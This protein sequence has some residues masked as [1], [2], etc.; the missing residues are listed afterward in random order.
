MKD[1]LNI[2]NSFTIFGL[3]IKYYGLIMALSYVLALVVCIILCRKKHYNENLPYKLLMLVFPLAVIG[4]RL[5]YVLFSDRSWTFMEVLD[6]RSGGLMLYGGI[7]LALVGVI[8]Y[9][10]IKNKNPLKYT[11]LIAPCLIIAQAL[12][13]WGNFFNQEAYGIAV[14]NSA[15]H[16]FPFAVFIEADGLWHYATFFYESMWCLICF[17]IL[18]VV[19]KKTK[20]AG[21]STSLYLVLYGTERLLVEGLRTDSLYL[22]TFRVSQLISIIMIAFGVV[23]LTILGIKTHKEKVLVQQKHDESNVFGKT[24]EE[25]ENKVYTKDDFVAVSDNPLLDSTHSVL[26]KAETS[27]NDR[28]EKIKQANRERKEKL[29]KKKQKQQKKNKK[30][31]RK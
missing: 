5:G 6:I 19:Y 22:G 28:V 2:N 15:F 10:F 26:N 23:Y 16:W 4:G 30:N 25:I 8:V 17:V 18:F 12:G 21:I 9:A 29:E 3:E 1:L 24:A 27:G 7:L 14:E 31:K 11:D 13:R 20:K